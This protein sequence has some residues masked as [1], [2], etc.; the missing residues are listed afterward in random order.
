MEIDKK[1][2]AIRIWLILFG[3]FYIVFGGLYILSSTKSPLFLVLFVASLLFLFLA[4]I[5]I[6]QVIRELEN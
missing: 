1:I 5:R 4:L 6:I 3:T 2:A